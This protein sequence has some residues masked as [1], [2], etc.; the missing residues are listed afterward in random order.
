MAR[1]TIGDQFYLDGK[2]FRIISGSI[3]YFR[4]H[5][6][7]WEDRLRKLR[8]MG[9]NTVETYVPWNLHQPEP[10]RFCFEDGL[11]IARFL[12]TAQRLGLYAIVRPSPYICAEW[13]FGGLPWWLL[14]GETIPLRSDEGPF[15]SLTAAYYDRLL[16]ILAPL[17]IDQ[18]GPILLMQ[19]ENEF[20][21]WWKSDPEYLIQ[22]AGL[23]R[24]GGIRVS[25]ITSDNLENDSLSRGTTPD[26]LPTLNFGSGA[27]EKLPLLR[28]YVKDGPLMVTEFWVGWFDAWGDQAHHRTDPA[29]SARCLAEILSQGSVN[30][31]MFHG[32]TNFG[33]MNG[34]NDYGHLTPDVT[35]YD[36]DA[37]LAEDGSLTEKYCRFREVIGQFAPLPPLESVSSPRLAPQTL[38]PQAFASLW[39]NLDALSVPHHT[40]HPLS[41]EQLGQGYGYIL[42]T[43]Q[44]PKDLQLRDLTLTHA[45]DRASFFMDQ[46]LLF[47]AFDRALTGPLSGFPTK[48]GTR[49]DI[50]AENMG[51]VNYGQ[52]ML[53]QRKGIDG[54]VLADG[55]ELKDW[56]CR[57]L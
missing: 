31:Y 9:C 43:T 52:R 11:D 34:S 55:K 41:M 56:I 45:A 12:R 38:H 3:H 57:P 50:L 40:D 10:D 24:K 15:L 4:V 8:A 20:G 6:D 7:L 13:E 14:S 16:P 25:L 2:P 30:F 21:A 48:S 47:T 28:P 26:A 22:L 46:H 35:S 27:A 19:V 18:G 44:L 42:Y 51:R 37:P 33:F 17:Q 29:E 36:Y 1:F 54:P 32:G 49:L 53:S 23:L 5:P 39:D